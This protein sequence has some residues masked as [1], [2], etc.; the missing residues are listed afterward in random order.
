M[1]HL[2]T[3]VLTL[4]LLTCCTTPARREAM[5]HGLDSINVRN[6]TDQPFTTADVQPYVDFFDRHGTANDRLLAHYLMGRAY[7]EQKD[8][9]RALRCYRDA[10]SCTN[11]DTSNIDHQQLSRVYGQM[12]CLF[13]Q[14]RA[15]QLE[16]E[17]EKAAISHAYM[18]KDTTGALI[19]LAYLSAPYHMLGK[20]DSA[21]YYNNYAILQ[22][23]KQGEEK[24]A[25][26]LLPMSIDIYLRRGDHI[27]AKSAMD[28]FEQKTDIFCDNGN[29]LPDHEQYYG[30][31]GAYY[32]GIGRLDSAAFYYRKLLACASNFDD[33][34]MA[35]E[36]LLSLYD[37]QH[38]YDSISK[39]AMLYCQANDSASFAHS[40]DEVTR[41]Q[42]LYN[43]EDSEYTAAKKAKE[44]EQYR[45]FLLIAILLFFFMI[46]LGYNIHKHY[47]RKKI[48]EM[49]AISQALGK[50]RNDLAR[51]REDTLTNQQ[52]ICEKEK[53]IRQLEKAMGRYGKLVFFGSER[54]ENDLRMSDSYKSIKD[55]AVR[56]QK[57]TADEWRLVYEVFAEYFPVCH[58]FCTSTMKIDTIEYRVSMLLRLHFETK[59]IANMSG[60]TPPYISKV[61]TKVLKDHFGKR[62]SSKDLAKELNKM[63]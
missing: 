53:R 19:F 24:L 54:I 8:V 29:I 6:R 51:L 42:A 13:N 9:P 25:C 44:A 48:E 1:K 26:G 45:N 58:D 5:R 43:Y 36:G 28:E 14:Q 2:L 22:L 4:T 18:A 30:Y 33:R 47:K 3:I 39:Y 40:A 50:A 20:M 17:A 52:A 46:Y 59:E 15:P 61:S 21:L 41:V 55:M 10:V 38:I 63:G 34:A 12:A 60:V 35:Y 57:L 49:Q 23:K 37:R 7:H 62:G 27:R 32:M 56:G 31:K 16:I 11:N